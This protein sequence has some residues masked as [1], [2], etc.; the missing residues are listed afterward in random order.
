MARMQA[1]KSIAPI[2]FEIDKQK[3]F[4]QTLTAILP[5]QITGIVQPNIFQI[6]EKYILEITGNKG[7]F[8]RAFLEEMFPSTDEME[9]VYHYTNLDALKG[10]ATTESLRLYAVEKRL[11]EGELDTFAKDHNLQGYLGST[12]G[13]SYFRT[14]SK[15]LF[16]ISFARSLSESLNH[17]RDFGDGG[18]GV[19]LALKIRIIE[20]RCDYRYI[21]YANPSRTLLVNL[22]ETLEKEG[23]PPFLPQSISKI[24]AF[25]LPDCLQYEDEA[26]LLIKRHC[27]GKDHAQQASDYEFWPLNISNNEFCEIEIVEVKA[28]PLAK[29]SEIAATISGTVL[30]AVPIT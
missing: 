20:K 19:R 2:Q 7:E 15:D 11:G 13:S 30:G 12:D 18:K 23:L 10:I 22:N 5:R 29:K 3:K 9:L 21:T 27:G 6:R 14:L 24:G 25:Y 4:Y 8:S 17:W 28:G 16:Y 1:M 26:R